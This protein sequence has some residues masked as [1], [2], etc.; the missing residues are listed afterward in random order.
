MPRKLFPKAHFGAVD[1]LSITVLV[2]TPQIHEY[3]Q[4]TFPIDCTTFSVH[5]VPVSFVLEC[6]PML[7][8]IGQVYT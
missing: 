6:E 3:S 8:Y 1:N 5:T 7:N 2:Y 4:S